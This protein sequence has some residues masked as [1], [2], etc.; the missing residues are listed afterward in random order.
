MSALTRMSMSEHRRV[1]IRR[2]DTVIVSASPIPG[3]ER[4]IGR[5]INRLFK[6]G[7]EVIYE[8]FSGVH[9]SG[10]AS[11][12]ELKLMLNL[13]KPKYFIPVHGEY[14]HLIK[15]ARLAEEVGIPAR[16][17]VI[18]DLGD[19][20]QF[21]RHKD[22]RVSGRVRAG[23][24]F[25]DGVSVGDIG[26]IVLKDRRLLAQDGIVLATIVV[27]S[28]TGQVLKGPDIFTRGFIYVRESGELIESICKM[29]TDK[30]EKLLKSDS[31]DEVYAK[32][33][34]RDSIS[35]FLYEKTGRRPMVIPVVMDI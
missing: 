14:R 15:H 5:T 12:E 2:G 18:P 4:M 34:L 22:V 3:N 17:I 19:V 8:A 11:Q 23:R 7:A 33:T 21:D 13:V 27:D 29:V 6:Q 9:V 31:F 30:I 16:N 24:V 28:E 1:S 10:H 25:V 35:S 32:D 20:I 26:D